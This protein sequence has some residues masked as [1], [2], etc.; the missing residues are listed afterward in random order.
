MYTNAHDNVDVLV[1]KKTQYV[2]RHDGIP[3]NRRRWPNIRLIL[4]H[5]LRCWPNINPRPSNVVPGPP[6]GASSPPRAVYGGATACHTHSERPLWRQASLPADRTHLILLHPVVTPDWSFWRRY[7]ELTK[8]TC[9]WKVTTQ[10][11]NMS[12]DGA[13]TIAQ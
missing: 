12:S 1:D 4:A 5:R 3:E 9:I 2:L 7:T 6:Y 8:T 13:T 11:K 10:H